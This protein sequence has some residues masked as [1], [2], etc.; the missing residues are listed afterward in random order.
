MIHILKANYFGTTFYSRQIVILDSGRYT[1]TISEWGFLHFD[2][3]HQDTVAFKYF[4]EDDISYLL[5]NYLF[6]EDSEEA[7]YAR[8]KF[9]KVVL[10]FDTENEKNAFIEYAN[11]NKGKFTNFVKDII[12]FVDMRKSTDLTDELKSKKMVKVYRAFIRMIIQA[13]RYC[14]GQSRQFAGDGL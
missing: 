3:Y 9:L 6:K 5:H 10:V 1:T 2:E 14:G 11:C 8:C 7:A 12:L 13:I 4:V